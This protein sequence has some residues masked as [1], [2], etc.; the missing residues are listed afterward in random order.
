MRPLNPRIDGP[1]QNRAAVVIAAC[2]L[3][4]A[5]VLGVFTAFASPLTGNTRFLALIWGLV[6]AGVAGMLSGRPAVRSVAL[7]AYG[8]SLAT[9]LTVSPFSYL[10]DYRVRYVPAYWVVSP[11]DV[12]LAFLLGSGLA[13]THRLRPRHLQRGDLLLPLAFLA[14]HVASIAPALN[15]SAALFAAL[16][17]AKF[18]LVYWFFS[19]N[20]GGIEELRSLTHGLVIGVTANAGIAAAQLLQGGG[21]GLAIL[22]E[23]PS[24][25]RLREVGDVLTS[26]PAGLF[27]HPADLALFALLTLAVLLSVGLTELGVSGWV[28]VFAAASCIALAASRTVMVI[29]LLTIFVYVMARSGFRRPSRFVG[30]AVAVAVPLLGACALFW[31]SL[32]PIFLKSDLAAQYGNRLLHVALG[33]SEVSRSW[34]LGYGANNYADHMAATY[35]SQFAVDFFLSNPIHNTYLQY[36]FDLGIV[37]LIVMLALHLRVILRSVR[38][39]RAG[40]ATPVA[41]MALLVVGGLMVYYFTGWSGLKEP[42]ITFFWIASGLIYNRRLTTPAEVA[43]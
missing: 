25:T 24:A 13:V 37:G 1:S 17:I 15:R 12:V 20:V 14:V 5:A 43:A 18:V 23:V 41:M 27:Q 36:W 26:A 6:G 2:V 32:A 39:L 10:W 3:G 19:R 40:N 9:S 34:V 21:L 4:G 8:A 11:S 30:R 35:P 28:G 16:R 42:M 33:W 29:A 38:L 31:E 7:V 22:G